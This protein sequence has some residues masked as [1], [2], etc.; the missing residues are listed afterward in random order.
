[1]EL[2]ALS[3]SLNAQAAMGQLIVKVLSESADLVEKQALQASNMT[4]Q[5]AAPSVSL[6][7][8]GENIDLYA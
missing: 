6:G 2:A 4:T 1:M 8:Y 7:G 3:N 5:S